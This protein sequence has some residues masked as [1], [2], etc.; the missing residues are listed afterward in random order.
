LKTR[1]IVG[2]SLLPLLL[3]V[4]SA[5]MFEGPVGGSAIGLAVGLLWDMY[6]ARIYGGRAL[7]FM[8]LGCAC[9]L[10]VRLLIRNNLLSALLLSAVAVAVYGFGDWLLTYV[11]YGLG[12]PLAVLWRLV[13][14]R[15]GY[16]L[17]LFPI[18]YYINY[19][20]VRLLKDRS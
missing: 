11:L 16:T 12:E 5:A 10:L 18:V 14:P 7:V 6:S 4:V 8:A 2:L 13:L 9:G 19:G 20:C 1:I 15:M 17:A 3:L